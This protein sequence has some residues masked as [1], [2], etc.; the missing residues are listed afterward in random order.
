[1]IDP[2]TGRPKRVMQFL[3][4]LEADIDMS[5]VFRSDVQALPGADAAAML[6][7]DADGD[8]EALQ[9]VVIPADEPPPPPPVGDSPDIKVLRKA[10]FAALQVTGIAPELFDNYA[11]KKWHGNWSHITETLE[12][13]R[14]ELLHAPD[15]LPAYIEQISPITSNDCPF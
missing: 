11:K 8:D 7:H 6:C 9:G 5:R 15:N 12:K 2:E 1:M 10:V 4:N 14:S 3:V 13:A